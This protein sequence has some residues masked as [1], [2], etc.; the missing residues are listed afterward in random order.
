MRK[1]HFVESVPDTR[2]SGQSHVI[3]TDQFVFAAS[4]ALS[5]DTPRR[6]DPAAVTIADEARICFERLE[7][8]LNAAGCGL[9]DVAKMTCYLSDRAHQPEFVEVYKKY[10]EAGSYPVRCT[11]FV[12]LALDC[13]I[14]IDCIAVKPKA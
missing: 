6:R 12:G 8:K 2:A 4:M 1:S 10:W 13:R 14:E 7:A 9:K 5:F 11:F 3:E